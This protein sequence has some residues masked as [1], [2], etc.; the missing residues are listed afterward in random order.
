[1]RLLRETIFVLACLALLA[2]VVFV[3]A[4]AVGLIPISEAP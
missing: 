3:C 2:L 1:M 4:L